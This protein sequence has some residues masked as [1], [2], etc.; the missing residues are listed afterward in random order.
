MDM[1][2]SDDIGERLHAHARA[3]FPICRSITGAGLRETLAYIARHI[4]LTVTEVP[5]GTPVLDWTVP[6]EWTPRAATIRRLS[7]EVVVDFAEH[8]LHLLQ[9]SQAVDRVMP[10]GELDQHLYSLPDQPDLIPYRT[11][12]Y[13]ESWGFCLPH[14]TRLAMA[15]PEYRV[16]IDAELAPGSLS[17]GE[18]VIPGSEAGEILLSVHSCHPSLA[19][20]N[21][22]GI[23]VAIEFA[24][25]WAA[26]PHRLGLRV[27]FLPGTIGAITW[28]ARNRERL[29]HVAHGLVLTCLG[30]AGPPTYKRSRRDDAAIDRAAAHALGEL[31]HADRV[32][33]FVPYG[34]DERQ[35]CSP[36]FN[37]PVGCLMRSPNGSFPEYHTS[38]D[39]LD[40]IRPDALAGSLALLERVL[41]I[42]EAD[43]PWR[44]TQPFGEPQLGRRGLYA[45]IG[46]AGDAGAGAAFDQLTML[47][48]LNQSDGGM[49]LLEI[50][51]RAGKPFDAVQAAAAALAEAG[52]LV[53]AD[54]PG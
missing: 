12:Y 32:R 49:S 33:P 46:G 26:R 31:G 9:Y 52:L 7:G 3:L 50:A 45:K 39:A 14:R 29:P 35:Y 11:A 6:L 24:K 8:S 18:C 34:Y 53:P 10:R 5:S 25:L 36:G 38:A 20:D 28:L 41:A 15:D 16:T 1:A 2:A 43:R 17:Y 47:W 4:P 27:V 48:V 30:D 21:L 22:S 54:Q 51:E 23:A 37:L 13:A 19:N 44:N 40:F 42:A